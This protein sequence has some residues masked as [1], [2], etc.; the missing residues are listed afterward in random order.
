MAL[1]D[2]QVRLQ[3]EQDAAIAQALGA[4]ERV[5]IL[6]ALAT[7]PEPLGLKALAARSALD[8]SA[9]AAHMPLLVTLGVVRR[10]DEAVGS[11]QFATTP[12][13]G[14]LR[15]MC[16]SVTREQDEPRSESVILATL[17]DQLNSGVA[18][19]DASGV[20]V[21][22]NPAGARIM[23][24]TFIP[25][26]AQADRLERYE[27]RRSDGTIMP[28]SESPSGRAL[29]GE[30]V[31]EMEG[32]IDVHGRD[33]WLRY[34]ASPLRDAHGAISGALVIFDD[35][36]E[37]RMLSHEEALQRSL[38]ETM[39]E[40]T[41]SG[42]AVFDA[43]DAFR[44]V[45]HNDNFLQ[46]MGSGFVERG[47]IVD[48]ALDDLFQGAARTRTR[49][50]EI[51]ERV[52]A[53]GEPYVSNEFSA[54]IPPDKRRRSYR[55]RL[56]P[57]RG[58]RGKITGL[59]LVVFEI[60]ELVAAREA[61]RRH[62]AELSAIIEAMPEAVMLVERSGNVVLSNSAVQHILGHPVTNLLDS[63]SRETRHTYLADGRRIRASDLP[64]SRAFNGETIVGE[65]VVYE[66]P[67][68]NR[69]DLL[70]SAAPLDLDDSGQIS[71]AV[72]VFQ[73]ITRIKEL[74]RQRDDFL[75]IAAHELRTPLATIL[76]T[77][78]AFLRRMH[79]HPDGRAISP[80]ALM[81]GLERMYRQ[82]QRLNKLVS[83]LL[84][85]TRMRTGKL[86]YDLE[87]CD[88]V[89]VVRDAVA[90]QAAANPERT[91]TLTVPKQPV[92]VMGDAFRL[93]Q[94]VDNLVANAAKY[95]AAEMTVVISL[96]VEDSHAVLRVIDK[97][98]GIP[99]ENIELLFTR[100]YRVPG[101]D[102]QSGPGVGL[103]LGLHIT[104]GVVD[105]HG[106]RIEVDSTPGKGST[107]IVTLPL[108]ENTGS[109]E[110]CGEQNE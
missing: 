45:R 81:S 7:A 101:V 53:T 91:F 56:S 64:L 48:V 102:V 11:Y 44:C 96:K 36:T 71:A 37:Q 46:M 63:R 103:G 5:A 34:Y 10:S 69:I 49:V 12:L 105:R 106:G 83:D 104:S 60:T 31:S 85:A 74:E 23:G 21:H 33:I 70:T 65:E 89:G 88:L 16:A 87:P 54:M 40:Q 43:T 72:T 25:G 62:A 75:G 98:V 52:R 50:R 73:D 95:S 41:F 51:F 9:I 67:G 76:A 93:S 3:A 38:A 97:G 68:G 28:V 20:L 47:S 58:E 79:N 94:V 14:V 32:I 82:S 42:M 86:I 109:E 17:F 22:L 15:A 59:L 8:R 108:L 35:I 24:Q 78:Q 57:V 110:T 66:R 80:E 99:P 30:V 1:P 107:F 90:G 19:Y 4:P 84:D 2:E 92:M 61:S 26:E 77:L 6:R 100:F 18:L 39:I 27:M 55:M 13:A 29:R